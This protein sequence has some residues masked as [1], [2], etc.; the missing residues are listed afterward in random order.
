MQ[1]D[2]VTERYELTKNL[3]VRFVQHIEV[4]RHRHKPSA[5]ATKLT[6]KPCKLN[7]VVKMT[8]NVMSHEH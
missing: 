2:V 6:L 7:D 5:A 8:I 1:S 4:E 3:A